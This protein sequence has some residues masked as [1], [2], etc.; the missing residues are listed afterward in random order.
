MRSITE[1]AKR[2]NADPKKVNDLLIKYE[3]KIYTEFGINDGFVNDDLYEHLEHEINLLYKDSLERDDIFKLKTDYIPLSFK[4]CCVYFLIKDNTIVY[5]GQTVNLMARTGEHIK[6]KDFNYIAYIPTP[7]RR[8]LRVE[9]YYIVK[10][11]PL[12]NLVGLSNITLFEN[13]IKLY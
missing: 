7:K 6:N 5:V 9:G 3:V 2:F 4:D 11:N 10:F 13:L 8:L 12:Y 1:I